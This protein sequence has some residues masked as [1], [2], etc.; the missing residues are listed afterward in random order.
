[1]QV[2]AM[3]KSAVISNECPQLPLAASRIVA[4]D[5]E[6]RGSSHFAIEWSKCVSGEDNDT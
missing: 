5:T 2:S 6:E 4:S 1:M 3:L